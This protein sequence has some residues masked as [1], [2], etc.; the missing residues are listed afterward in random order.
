MPPQRRIELILESV[1]RLLRMGATPN[2]LN[3]LQKQ[4]PADLAQL[5][6]ELGQ[7]ERHAAFNTLVE[8][9]GRARHGGA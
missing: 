2:L 6:T 9:N 3:L 1:R 8:K 4:H 5:F 7:K